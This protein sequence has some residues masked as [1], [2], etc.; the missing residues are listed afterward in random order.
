MEDAEPLLFPQLV[1]ALLIITVVN[2]CTISKDFLSVS[3]VT[4]QVSLVEVCLPSF[5]VFDSST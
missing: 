1:I 5:D 2:V 4:N 3:L